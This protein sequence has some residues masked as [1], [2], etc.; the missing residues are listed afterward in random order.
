MSALELMDPKM[1]ALGSEPPQ[2]SVAELLKNL[3][4]DLAPGPAAAILDRLLALEVSYHGG[5]SL[6]DSILECVALRGSCYRSVGDAS[7]SKQVA[8]TRPPVLWV[9][10]A[11]REVV[12]AADIFEEEDFATSTTK[13]SK[14]VEEA[15]RRGGRSC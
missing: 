11:A 4:V 1:D 5:A 13:V 9:C 10:E 2:R 14:A 8:R 7:P 12:V 6:H 3:P 15:R